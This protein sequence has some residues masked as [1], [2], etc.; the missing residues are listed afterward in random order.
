[1]KKSKDKHKAVEGLVAR[2]PDEEQFKDRYIKIFPMADNGWY[3]I[4]H[5]IQDKKT[6]EQRMRLTESALI[7]FFRMYC[8]LKGWDKPKGTLE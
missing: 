6:V 3:L 1:M 2:M 4:A 8:Q 7:M 5:S